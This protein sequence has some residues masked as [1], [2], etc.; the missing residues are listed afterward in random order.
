MLPTICLQKPEESI[1]YMLSRVINTR[2]IPFILGH[3]LWL[4]PKLV[5]LIGLLSTRVSKLGSDE[6]GHR[7][8][9]RIHFKRSGHRGP[10]FQRPGS[11][12]KTP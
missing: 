3:F 11:D 9:R 2:K 12:D 10:C 7:S 5:V 8:G 1:E 6:D 4:F